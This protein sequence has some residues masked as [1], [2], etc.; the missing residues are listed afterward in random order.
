[1]PA[2]GAFTCGRSQI[3]DGSY[4]PWFARVA[5]GGGLAWELSLSDEKSSDC[6]G[7]APLPDGGA[8][9]IGPSDDYTMLAT[10]RIGADGKLLSNTKT[11]KFKPTSW[12][13]LVPMADASLFAASLEGEGFMAGKV[14]L[15]DGNGTWQRVQAAAPGKCISYRV[16]AALAD[17]FLVACT[18]SSSTV[19]GDWQPMLVRTDL[20]GQWSCASSG[21]C[22]NKA[23]NTCNDGN[24]CTSDLC[25]GAAGGCVFPP[26]PDGAPGGGGKACQIGKCL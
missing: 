16:T 21:S 17:G 7:I 8:L 19:S 20:W 25:M 2:G 11:A 22:L 1:M 24:P 4:F 5:A 9:A 6:T 3:K 12:G 10:W 26:L 23:A 15:L 13:K 14:V 18:A